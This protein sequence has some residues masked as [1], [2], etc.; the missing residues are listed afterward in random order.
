MALQPTMRKKMIE[1]TREPAALKVNSIPMKK[2]RHTRI[3]VLLFA[4][5]SFVVLCLNYPVTT[6]F[7]GWPHLVFSYRAPVLNLGDRASRDYYARIDFGYEDN[8]A[9]ER[10]K[11]KIR[12]RITGVYTISNEGLNRGETKLIRIL[13][14]LSEG[15][16]IKEYNLPGKISK[17]MKLSVESEG[18]SL[19][20]TEKAIKTFFD[21]LRFSGIMSKADYE[22]EDKNRN[23]SQINDAGATHPEKIYA[24]D[25]GSDD[26]SFEFD[27]TRI[28][29]LSQVLESKPY[30]DLTSSLRL[31]LVVPVEEF[32]KENILKRPTLIFNDEMTKRE[33]EKAS[34]GIKPVLR[35]KKKGDP[36]VYRGER[37]EQNIKDQIKAENL[38]YYAITLEDWDRF[39]LPATGIAIALFLIILP[40]YQLLKRQFS[41][42]STRHGL[43]LFLIINIAVLLFGRFFNSV[44]IQPSF[45]PMYL[46]GIIFALAYSREVALYGLLFQFVGLSIIF[47]SSFFLVLAP[48]GTALAA[49]FLCSKIETRLHI[50]RIGVLSGVILFVGSVGGEFLNVYATGIPIRFSFG[51]GAFWTST[52]ISSLI[53]LGVTLSLS[54]MLPLIERYLGVITN[55]TLLELSDM[56]NPC[57]KATCE[58]GSR[59]FHA[60]NECRNSVRTVC[61]CNRCKSTSGESR[62][63]LPRHWK[64]DAP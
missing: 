48:A 39:A 49:I 15:K 16:Q 45:I 40:G 46:V 8:V 17:P 53:A 38:R 51:L 4:V 1:S 13:K 7:N 35:E 19:K 20:Q 52:L 47:G 24:T 28:Q 55:V 61:R 26:L 29:L 43:Y 41:I 63:I 44:G 54:I 32:L 23:P 5:I 50:L 36:I 34:V 18:F 62:C 60:C 59:N 64:A 58:S 31:S 57:L 37:V 27:F 21:A 12:E 25:G 9:T 33:K 11:D 30:K 14:A 6:E 42:F 22:R 2:R 56:N 3:A 10:A